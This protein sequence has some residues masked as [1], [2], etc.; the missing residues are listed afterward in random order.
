MTD[1]RRQL[2]AWLF[3]M[4]RLELQL[5]LDQSRARNAMIRQ[6]AAQ[7]TKT[8]EFPTFLLL[9]HRNRTAQNLTA[10]YQRTIPVFAKLA[11]RQI[12]SRR[13]E[14]KADTFDRLTAEWIS[15][16]ALRKARLIADHDRDEVL[17]AINTG[18]EEG[19]GTEEI[20]RNIRAVSQMTRTRADTI[21]RT[22]THAAATFGSIE[23][24][25]EAEEEL[26][27]R[28]LKV[29]L[30]T[31]DGR[32]RPDHAAMA[33]HPPIPLDEKFTVGGEMMDRPGDPSASAEQV[34][35]C[36]CALVYE[37]AE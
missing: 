15:R 13:F 25:R 23:S 9:D 11:T 31:N 18:L 28:M 16:E 4:T 24:V 2:R 3:A 1:R 12:K 17:G 26:G 5:R 33:N 14:R 22:E 21:A 6:A 29:W 19:L 8:R 37:E 10:A 30:P 27:V 34:I 36:R 35:G 32:A 7:F 20:A